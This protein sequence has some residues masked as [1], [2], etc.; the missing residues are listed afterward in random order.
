MEWHFTV[1]QGRTGWVGLAKRSPF[2]TGHPLTEPGEIWFEFG[3]T[4]EEALKAIKASVL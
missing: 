1:W 3:A 4:A 2:V